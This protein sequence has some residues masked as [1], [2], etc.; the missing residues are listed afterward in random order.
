MRGNVAAFGDEKS[1][2]VLLKNSGAIKMTWNELTAK[3]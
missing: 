2:A 3:P 1:A